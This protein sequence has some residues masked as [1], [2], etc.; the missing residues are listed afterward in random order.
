M[1]RIITLLSNLLFGKKIIALLSGLLFGIGLIISQMVD[2][3]KIINFLDISG[4][5]DPSLMFVMMGALTVYGLGYWVFVHRR[6]KALLGDAMPS[7]TDS[8]IDKHLVI[9][10][11]IFG[12]GWGLAGFCPGPVITN[13]SSL[14]PK[15]LVFIAVMMI[16][17]KIGGVIK[18]RIN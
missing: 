15:I 17:M 6:V 9:G 16:G 18:T 8:Q 3:Q 5:W 12:L 2:P 10:A 4:N 11:V 14:D 1:R 13:A 7:R